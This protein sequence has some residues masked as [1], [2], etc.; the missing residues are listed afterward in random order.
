[1]KKILLIGGTGYIG[2]ALYEKL[3]DTNEVDTLD[4]EWFGNFS[5]PN[6]IKKDF[7]EL[8]KEELAKYD[9]IVLTA[10]NSSV[11]LCSEIFDTFDNNVVKFINLVKKLKKQKFIYASSACV[12]VESGSYPKSETDLL[13]PIDG[14][15]LTKTTI[16]SFMPHTNIEYY[17][18]RFGS[19]NGY[20][21]NMRL[22]LMI[23]SMTVSAMYKGE[24][25]VFN[26]DSYRPITSI[27][28]LCNSVNTIIESKEDKR[29]IYNIASFN[30][31]ILEIG[32]RVAKY[33]NVP[34]I[35]RGDDFTYNFSC[36]MEKFK[37]A[38]DFEFKSS[39]ESVTGGIKGH[40]FNSNWQ[41][42]EIINN[43]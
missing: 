14:L 30:D 2:S 38:F 42:R 34:L 18:L 41:K 43:I 1:M 22:D 9:I 4:L 33:M 36:S 35:D 31:T 32:N 25:N 8:T 12:Y 23:N 24:V 39:V 17:G 28:D 6:N 16:D 37:N 29:G 7:D 19:V 15:T 13:S 27:N 3:K 10:A 20:A 11:P 26:G 40:Y 21:P 5:N